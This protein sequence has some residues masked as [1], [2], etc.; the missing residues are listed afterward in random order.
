M[1]MSHKDA[2][3]RWCPFSRVV[4]QRPGDE[5]PVSGYN[6]VVLLT[7]AEGG[8]DGSTCMASACM[9]WRFRGEDLGYCGLAGPS[10]HRV[11]I[12]E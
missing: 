10:D 7:G 2:K 12:K 5:S 1:L 8:P 6:R 3:S 9:A 4:T 11:Q